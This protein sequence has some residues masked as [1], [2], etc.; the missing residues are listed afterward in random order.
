ME[1]RNNVQS[2]NFG[3]AFRIKPVEGMPEALNRLSEEAIESLQKA[4]KILGKE[5]EPNATKYYHVVVDLN[6]SGKPI[7]RLDA[8]KDAY[9]G[10]FRHSMEDG[11]TY[12]GRPGS[13]DNIIMLSKEHNGYNDYNIAGVARYMSDGEVKPSFNAWVY[14][15]LNKP[16]DA[17]DLAEIAKILD[18]VAAQKAYEKSQVATQKAA[19]AE[20]ISTDVAN[21]MRDFSIQE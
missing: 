9:F 7:V 21:L 5:G 2:P 19:K 12:L 18:S 1:I 6:K 20:K 17:S 16:E 15:S 3:M 8:D 4:G 10:V 13:N 11:S 14:D